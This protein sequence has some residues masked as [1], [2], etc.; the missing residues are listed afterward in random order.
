MEKDSY[1]L[2]SER[3][4]YGVICTAPETYSHV[5]IHKVIVPRLIYDYIALTLEH[6]ERYL[7]LDRFFFRFFFFF[8]IFF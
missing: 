6:A 5:N 4:H 8:V 7:I 1:L 3:T 2:I